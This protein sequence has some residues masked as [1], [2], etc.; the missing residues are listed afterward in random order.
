LS[1][2]LSSAKE[3]FTLSFVARIKVNRLAIEAVDAVAAAV[4][5]IQQLAVWGESYGISP[6][7]RPSPRSAMAV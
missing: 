5:L 6:I 7:S 4:A 1:G 2:L 3:L